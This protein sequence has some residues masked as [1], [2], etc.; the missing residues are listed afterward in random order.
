MQNNNIKVF[1]LTTFTLLDFPDTPAAII[2]LAGCNMRCPYCHN[3]DIVFGKN[4]LNF[5]EVIKFLN[6]RKRV[7]E[8]VVISG[9]EPTLHKDIFKICKSI[10]ELGYK[11]K[12]DT[13]GSNPDILKKLI[14]KGYLDYVAL[15]FKGPKKKFE[16]IAKINSYEQTLESIEILIQSDIEYE[17]RTTVHTLLLNENDINEIID[18][19]KNMGYKKRYFIQNYIHIDKTL[20]DIGFQE[21]FIEGSLLE[22]KIDIEFRNFEFKNV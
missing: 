7:L 3:P 9:G 5:D 6:K 12:L 19:L 1:D 21:R 2:W 18:I 22:K 13:N 20:K 14:E 16:N 17:I 4:S 8:G 15:D 10:K 11:I